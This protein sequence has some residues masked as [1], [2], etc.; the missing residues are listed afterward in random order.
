M[1]ADAGF[2]VSSDG[3]MSDEL[4]AS[5]V[6]SGD[7]AAIADR[8][9]ELLAAGLDEL[10]VMPV[11]VTDATGELARLTKLVGQL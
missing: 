11:P 10:L 7:D 4:I 2:P 1:F 6:V 5:L 9:R 8:L 3:T